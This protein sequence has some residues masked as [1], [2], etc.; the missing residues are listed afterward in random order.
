MPI[1]DK[2]IKKAI[3]GNVKTI[4][5][6]SVIERFNEKI[7]ANIENATK[8]H[9]GSELIDF[10]SLGEDNY[11]NPDAVLLAADY[12]SSIYG[13]YC[14]LF[15]RVNKDLQET[16]TAFKLWK[17]EK[18]DLIKNKLMKKNI[19]L[20]MTANNAKPTQKDVENYFNNK[21]SETSNFKKWESRIKVQEERVSQLRIMRDT[22]ESR[23]DMIKTISMLL[24]KSIESGLI[25]TSVNKKSF[26]KLRKTRI[27]NNDF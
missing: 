1:D 5:I 15:H 12:F 4:D 11:D 9:G 13:Y 10:L 23:K 27:I 14:L 22:I 16:G 26:N 3:S 21:F 25:T 19:E 6:D 24:I 7:L 8:K 18:E 2:K 17:S 20:G